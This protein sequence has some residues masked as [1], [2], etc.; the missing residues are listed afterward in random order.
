MV[1][2]TAPAKPIPNCEPD[3]VSLFA[4]V[5]CHRER[6]EA[7]KAA[8][9]Q[10]GEFDTYLIYGPLKLP[11]FYEGAAFYTNIYKVLLP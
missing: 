10:N 9:K 6:E 5:K 11:P 2:S 8:R 4:M 7:L 3:S 1:S